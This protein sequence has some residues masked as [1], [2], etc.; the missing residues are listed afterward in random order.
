MR[1]YGNERCSAADRRVCGEHRRADRGSLQLT[2]VAEIEPQISKHRRRG[3]ADPARHSQQDRDPRS[4]GKTE[5]TRDPMAR[6]RW[7]VER[8]DTG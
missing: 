4:A 3:R 2:A 7:P 6:H 8:T 1:R 5:K